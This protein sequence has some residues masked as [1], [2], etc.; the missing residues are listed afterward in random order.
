MLTDVFKQCYLK[1]FISLR[2][3]TPQNCQSTAGLCN[4]KALKWRS[5]PRLH[6]TSSS[7]TAAW[8]HLKCNFAYFPAR[9][10]LSLPQDYKHQVQLMQGSEYQSYTTALPTCGKLALQWG[11]VRGPVWAQWQTR[12]ESLLNSWIDSPVS[13]VC[14]QCHQ[15]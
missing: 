14:M 12:L 6:S 5:E 8:P 4:D 7:G 1:A 9:L 3:A 11:S 15:F 2:Q 13:I 10:Y